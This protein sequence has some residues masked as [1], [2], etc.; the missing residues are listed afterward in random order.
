M[1]SRE[2]NNAGLVLL[3]AATL[4]VAACSNDSREAM[5]PTPAAANYAPT[6]SAVADRTGDQD[7][8]VGPIEFSVADQE[9]A[10]TS[11]TVTAVADGAS[12]VPADGLTLGGSGA[13]RT[14]TLAPLEAA[15]GAVNVTLTVTDPDGAVAAR[16]FKV[17]VNARPASV[18]E[19]TLS[20]FAKGESD[21]VTAVN[22]FTFAQDAEDPAIFEPL[23]G[24]E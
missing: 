21:E 19:T 1:Q 23:F 16:A 15:T 4:V 9:S 11:L 14:I 3:A 20:T 13:T 17:M 5:Q 10:A 6:L 8:V 24:A 7:T 2:T 18:R 12:V 22:G